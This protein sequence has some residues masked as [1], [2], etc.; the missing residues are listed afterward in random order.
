MKLA[1]KNGNAGIESS[2]PVLLVLAADHV[3]N[4]I[5]GFQKAINLALPLAEAGKLLTFGVVPTGPETGYGYIRGGSEPN[6]VDSDPKAVPVA[7]FVEKPD[8]ETAEKYISTGDYYWNSGMFMFKA[9]CYLRELE[10]RCPDIFAACEEA[11][12]MAREDADFI[13]VDK[14]SF[15]AC[16]ADSIDYAVMEKTRE[17]FC[18]AYGLRVE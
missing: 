13:R 6:G 4:D 7:E 15:L 10:S 17:C 1:E 18:S 9:S 3:I 11:M 2:D 16:P 5:A 12:S 8:L 14:E